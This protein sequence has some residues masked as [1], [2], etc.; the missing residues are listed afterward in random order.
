MTLP[1]FPGPHAT[2]L[3]HRG[4][5]PERSA[6]WR[7][8]DPAE[9]YSEHVLTVNASVG[10]KRGGATVREVLCVVTLMGWE[11]GCFAAL[12]WHL[13]PNRV[14][15]GHSSAEKRGEAQKEDE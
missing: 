1:Q 3:R 9:D 8:F 2:R 5:I 10:R 6:P 14:G 12:S 15:D 7:W 4:E 11:R 13:R